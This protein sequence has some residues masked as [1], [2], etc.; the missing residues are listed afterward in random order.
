MGSG[1]LIL[2]MSCDGV[3]IRQCAG[4]A[5][6]MV[7]TQS[8][9]LK[10][11][12]GRGLSRSIRYRVVRF[13]RTRPDRHDVAGPEQQLSWIHFKVL[14]PLYFDEAM[15]LYIRQTLNARRSGR[16]LRKLVGR[17]VFERRE[18]TD[19][20][21]PSGSALQLATFS[22]RYCLTS[23]GSRMP[24]RNGASK[25]RSASRWNRFSRSRQ[26]KGLR[27]R[28]QC[29]VLEMHMDSIV[30]DKYGT[31]L[32]S[33]EELQQHIAQTYGPAKERVARPT[34]GSAGDGEDDK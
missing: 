30:A 32:S 21:D 26:R 7:A 34:L 19:A 2:Y 28:E 3:Q 12:C 17:Q 4:Y 15:V 24:T 1:E 33:K 29:K 31:A 13:A 27:S 11:R 18:I 10:K 5:Q 23:S 22:D 16:A 6:E 8:P 9:Q 20:Q 14:L 25:K